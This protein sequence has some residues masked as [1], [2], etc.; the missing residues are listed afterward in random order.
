MSNQIVN[1]VQIIKIK[2]VTSLCLPSNALCMCLLECSA[3]SFARILLLDVHLVSMLSMC[4]WVPKPK[5]CVVDCRRVIYIAFLHRSVPFNKR[6]L[7][8]RAFFDAERSEAPFCHS[9]CSCVKGISCLLLLCLSF[10]SLAQGICHGLLPSEW[11]LGSQ[12]CHTCMHRSLKEAHRLTHLRQR[13][14][15]KVWLSKR[16]PYTQIFKYVYINVYVY[17]CVYRCFYI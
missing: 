11:Q 10:S 17:I 16:D 3:T 6:C 7:K 2:S 4:A 8:H 1:A 5:L 9:L 13:T 14:G 15:L 12:C